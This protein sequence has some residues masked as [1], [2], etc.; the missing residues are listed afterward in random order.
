[1]QEF[2]GEN[3]KCNNT[4]YSSKY[5][6]CICFSFYSEYLEKTSQNVGGHTQTNK[7]EVSTSSPSLK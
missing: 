2:K 1:M 6:V 4:L 5:N 3:T 7:G